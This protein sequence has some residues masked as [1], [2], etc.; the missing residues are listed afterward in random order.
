MWADSFHHQVEMSLKKQKKV[1]DFADFEMCVSR[2]NSGRVNVR[3]TN[4]KDFLCWKDYSSL[5]KLAHATPRPILRAMTEVTVTR[6]KYTICYKNDFDDFSHCPPAI[7]HPRG[8][9]EEKKNGI[10]KNLLTLIPSNRHSFWK[11]L[12]TTNNVTDLSIDFDD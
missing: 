3:T 2:A 4:Q 5:Y 6:G 8:I 10:L 9:T 1:Y 12:P 7:D 11:N